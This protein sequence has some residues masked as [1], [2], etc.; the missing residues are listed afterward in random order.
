MKKLLFLCLVLT[1]VTVQAQNYPN[2]LNYSLNSTPVHGVKIKTN[3][4]FT[5]GTQMPTINIVGYSYGKP[6]TINLTLSYY[7][8]ATDLSDAS[9]NYFLYQTASSS[10][11]DAPKIFLSA[12]DGKV[13]IFI[14]D[15]VYHQRFTVSAYAKGM[16][17]ESSWFTGWTAV[18]EPIS[19]VKTVEVPYENAFRGNVRFAAEG[20]WK[21]DGSVGIGTIT[22]QE[23]LSVNG[24]IRAKEIKVEATNWPDYV[25]KPDYQ[26]NT[27]S[28]LEAYIKTY[29]HLP[30]VP[31]AAE[32]EKEGVALG[33][34][35]KILLKKIEELT[36]H[37]IE[38]EKAFKKLEERL[39]KLEN[40]K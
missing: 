12:E 15:K 3:L 18:D 6:L 31:A 4:P 32:V 19:G 9:T 17:E 2:L 8:Y 30:D 16:S 21:S 14:D 27:L 24:K 33:E 36:L 22:P 28:E 10:G 39:T 26:L 20:I 25:F 5:S 40:K 35:N 23:K 29:G 38:R 34:M 37:L 7:I 13:V 11:G 1:A